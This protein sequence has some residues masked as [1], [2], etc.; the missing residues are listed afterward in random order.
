MKCI[1]PFPCVF[2]EF[3][4]I[5]NSREKT[6]FVK[7]RVSYTKQAISSEPVVVNSFFNFTGLN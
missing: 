2:R 6:R 3:P 5:E 1:E 7:K 4:L